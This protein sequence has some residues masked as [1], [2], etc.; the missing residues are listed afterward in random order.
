MKLKDKIRILRK[1]RGYSQQDLGDRL[2]KETF[3]ISRQSVSDWE[4]G[5][6]E[7]KL[8]NIRE[9]AKVL[10]VSFDALLD[11]S[12]DLDDSETLMRV[13]NNAPK[14]ENRP[15]H[16]S[17]DVYRSHALPLILLAFILFAFL[18]HIIN[19]GRSINMSVADV[20]NAPMTIFDQ[21]IA[22]K[23]ITKSNDD[24]INKLYNYVLYVV[25]CFPFMKAPPIRPTGP[26]AIQPATLAPEAPAMVLASC[27]ANSPT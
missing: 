1:V 15:Y 19:V 25:T 17:I 22:V 7:P 9:L 24:N 14:D 3:G 20:E 16:G 12:I 11:D 10:N 4:N 8:D 26:K 5:N 6:S 23:L 2:S 21:I 13:L 27:S 18:F